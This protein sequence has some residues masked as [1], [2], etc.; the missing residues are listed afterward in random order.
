V[1]AF[2]FVSRQRLITR[3]IA[4]TVT[5]QEIAKKGL[6]YDMP[7]TS[8]VL[9]RRDLAFTAADGSPLSMDMYLPPGERGAPPPVVVLV[10]GYKD[11]GALKFLGCRFKE[12]QSNVSWARLIAASGMAAVMYTNR[13]PAADFLAALSHV[14]RSAAAHGVDGGRLGL[15]ASSGHGP[16]ALS[17]L[18][19]GAAVTVKCAALLYTFT[20]DL[21]GGSGVAANARQFGFVTPCAGKS[22]ADLVHDVPMFLVR[23]GRDHFQGLNEAMDR[24]TAE[25]LAANLPLTLVNYP[26]GPHAFD[27]F[28]DTETSRDIIK[29][30][31]GFLR[32]GLNQM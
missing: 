20:L 14:Q 28:A 25:A 7:G 5:P 30:V 1:V 22:A 27:L 23:A 31:L 10:S 21:D 9:V 24:F 2:F 32:F 19:R 4:M 17:A 13:E 6:V 3:R 18:M 12:M 29:S 15:W 16:V 26:E 11:E 8:D